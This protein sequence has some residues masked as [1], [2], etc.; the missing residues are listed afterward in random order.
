MEK[1]S[2]KAVL[3]YSFALKKTVV[4][5]SKE[6]ERERGRRGE[7]GDS[8]RF[9]D[10]GEKETTTCCALCVSPLLLFLSKG[11]REVASKKKKKKSYREHIVVVILF[12]LCV[13]SL[14]WITEREKGKEYICLG[15]C[16]SAPLDDEPLG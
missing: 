13:F 9:L 1:N 12:V 4:S 5:L 11:R 8:A 14:D 6:R 2:L 16:F 7:E 15:G 10:D 3:Y